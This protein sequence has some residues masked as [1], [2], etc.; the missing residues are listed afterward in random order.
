MLVREG[1]GRRV[2]S[3]FDST[4]LILIFCYLLGWPCAN[5]VVFSQKNTSQARGLNWQPSPQRSH[6]TIS[7]MAPSRICT[8]VE[9]VVCPS[10]ISLALVV[11]Y[12]STHAKGVA[13]SPHNSFFCALYLQ[14]QIGEREERSILHTRA[15][16]EQPWS[17]L[18]VA[19]RT[20]GGVFWGWFSGPAPPQCHSEPHK[21]RPYGLVAAAHPEES[22]H[23]VELPRVMGGGT[24]PRFQESQSP[25]TTGGW[26]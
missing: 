15:L 22:H 7:W 1:K 23:C 24:L 25:V 8:A 5:W 13:I 14:E 19:Q 12:T 2:E 6:P 10:C 16:P 11:Q 9:I 3:W 21:E 20:E 17:Q 4:L 26:P 18:S